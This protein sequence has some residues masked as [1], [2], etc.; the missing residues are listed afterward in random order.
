M[1]PAKG[2]DG[3][4]NIFFIQMAQKSSSERDSDVQG[5][6]SQSRNRNLDVIL[7]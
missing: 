2:D 1:R 6:K 5:E 3:G 4:N 7:M